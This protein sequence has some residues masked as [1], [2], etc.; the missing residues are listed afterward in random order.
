MPKTSWKDNDRVTAIIDR[1]LQWIMRR[2]GVDVEK[3]RADLDE[4]IRPDLAIVQE[5]LMGAVS[6]V[7]HER[8]RRLMEAVFT[9]GLW[10]WQRDQAYR[11]Q[12]DEALHR[13]CE[14]S[15]DIW[16]A[17]V[18]R[19]PPERWHINVVNARIE[20]MQ[21]TPRPPSRKP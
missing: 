18:P 4:D 2:A 15:P 11:W 12:L 16:G 5:C 9:Y 21:D 14:R 7:Q 8:T 10:K 19:K 3:M 13:L 1:G 20:R 17:M 6:D